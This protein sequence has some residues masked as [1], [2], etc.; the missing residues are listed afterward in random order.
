MRKSVTQEHKARYLDY[1]MNT[2]AVKR[3]TATQGAANRTE[4]HKQRAGDAPETKQNARKANHGQGQAT[5]RVPCLA[6]LALPGVYILN[7]IHAVAPPSSPK[8][9]LIA[10]R[11]SVISSLPP[12]P[13][14]S[15]AVQDFHGSTQAQLIE[16]LRHRPV[17]TSKL[18]SPSSDTTSVFAF[19]QPQLT[20]MPTSSK[21]NSLSTNNDRLRLRIPSSSTRHL[22]DEETSITS[23][24][25][26]I[27]GVSQGASPPLQT[28]I[29]TGP[30][31]TPNPNRPSEA[32]TTSPTLPIQPPSY[33]ALSCPISPSTTPT[34]PQTSSATL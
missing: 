23:P 12:V 27:G 24:S 30:N 8:L 15:S 20:E 28:P 9:L 7:Q 34:P 18:N 13:S 3:P 26:A 2:K 16:T 21:V 29:P 19:S 31:Q 4:L 14:S 32:S 6:R 10:H 17:L 11:R 25:S 22:M 1:L 33:P 5:G